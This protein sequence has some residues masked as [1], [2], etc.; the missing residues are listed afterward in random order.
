[1]ISVTHVPAGDAINVIPA[2]GELRGTARTLDPAVRDLIE[3]RMRRSS[4]ATAA[5]FGA[6]RK[7]DYRR[8]IR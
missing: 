8:T 1:M 5:A 7:L 2:D 6:E 3:K 4:S